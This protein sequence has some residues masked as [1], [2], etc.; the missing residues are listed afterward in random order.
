MLIAPS[1]PTP[2]HVHY[3]TLPHRKVCH[4]HNK[5]LK[6]KFRENKGLAGRVKNKPI[7]D[8]CTSI[9]NVSW[10]NCSRARVASSHPASHVCSYSSETASGGGRQERAARTLQLKVMYSSTSKVMYKSKLKYTFYNIRVHNPHITSIIISI[11]NLIYY[12]NPHELNWMS[13]SY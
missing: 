6:G 12:N 4:T 3:I 13:E 2:A 1:P 9:Y 8:K 7:T 10:E 11:S 5:L